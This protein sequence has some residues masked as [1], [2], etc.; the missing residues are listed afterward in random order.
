MLEQNVMHKA[1]ML[2]LGRATKGLFGWACIYLNLHV[3]K[4]TVVDLN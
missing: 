4:W 2:M 1:E 3:L